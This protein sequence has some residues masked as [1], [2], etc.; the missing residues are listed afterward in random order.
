MSDNTIELTEE[1]K[2]LLEVEEFEKNLYIRAEEISKANN[3]KKVI[4]IWYADPFDP[5]KGK[6]ITGFLMEPNRATKGAIAD[7]LMKSLYQGQQQAL[8]ASLIEK[9]S[10]ERFKS[11]NQAYDAVILAA[12]IAASQFVQIA[13]SQFK[14]K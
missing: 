7:T 8:A 9:E 2:K 1:Q 14:K 12:G 3:G 13:L 10:D 4:P 11:I 6:P 5:E